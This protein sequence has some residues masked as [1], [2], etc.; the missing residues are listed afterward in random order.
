VTTEENALA[1]LTQR[2][3]ELGAPDPGGW[4]NSEIMEGIAQQAKPGS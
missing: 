1:A 4:A 2:M 3:A